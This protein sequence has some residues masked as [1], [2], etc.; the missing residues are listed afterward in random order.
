MLRVGDSFQNPG[1]GTRFE[2]LRAPGEGDDTLEI[3]R[4][5]KPHSGKVV[6]HVH[7]DYR[8]HFVIESGAAI[9]RLGR[10]KL[11]LGPGDE[12]DVPVGQSHVNPYNAGDEDFVYRHSFAPASDFALAYVETL[13]HLM[14]ERRAD[15]QDE[16]PLPAAFA[17]GQAT[18]SR[19]Y[20]S[21]APHALQRALLFP[22]GARLA[23]RL[24]Y[25]LHLPG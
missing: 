3:R 22:V 19:T 21:I 12:L 4:H 20:A 8:E 6:P 16:V 10:R 7:L 13:G 2:V 18:A 1:T 11:R 5:S 25:Q 9:A 23:R 17:V 14:R 24:G 15:G